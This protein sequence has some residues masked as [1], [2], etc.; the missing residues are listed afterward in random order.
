MSDR[1]STSRSRTRRLANKSVIVA[2]LLG[3]TL[4][5]LAYLYVGRRKTA[6]L[7]LLTLNWFLLGEVLTPIHTYL[8]I[9]NARQRS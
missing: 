6:I 8:I 2:V 5:P 9:R 7:N 4:S 1:S 3:A